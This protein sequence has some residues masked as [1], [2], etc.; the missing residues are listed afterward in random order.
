MLVMV[1]HHR[2]FT[3]A[4]VLGKSWEG[5]NGVLLVSSKGIRT[6]ETCAAR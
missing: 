2:G 3:H 6:K 4:R 1:D 5:D